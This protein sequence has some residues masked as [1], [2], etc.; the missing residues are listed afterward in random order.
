MST[1]PTLTVK[2]SLVV[3]R[4]ENFDTIEDLATASNLTTDDLT[5]EDFENLDTFEP[6]ASVPQPIAQKVVLDPD[7]DHLGWVLYFDSAAG[8]VG[9]ERDEAN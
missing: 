7:G 1:A 3:G 6:D 4:S 2:Y 5:F 8:F 9:F